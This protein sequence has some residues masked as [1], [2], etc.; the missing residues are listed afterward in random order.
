MTDFDLATQAHNLRVDRV[1]LDAGGCLS[2]AG[3]PYALIKGPTTSLWL[4]APPRA[5]AD[6]DLLVPASRLR[7]A[8]DALHAGGIASG[9]MSGALDEIG[10]SVELRNAAG[11]E[12][13]LHRSLPSLP[14]N[15]DSLWEA[16]A[17]HLVEFDLGVGSLPALDEV[18][19]CLTIAFHAVSGGGDL[20]RRWDDLKL[21]YAK[22]DARVWAEARAIAVRLGA[23]DLFDAAL[24]RVEVPPAAPLSRR[25]KLVLGDAEADVIALDRLAR[26]PWRHLPAFVFHELWPTDEFIRAADPVL[27]DRRA[28][29]LRA[30]LRRWWRLTRRFP[31]AFRTF[32]SAR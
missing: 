28:G 12:I 24:S 1:A 21:A 16:L 10:H 11:F 22:V 29:L 30:R 9:E 26:T 5:Y 17:G 32:R 13:D 2:R 31:A 25:A 23:E 19:R 20:S 8:V 27:A 6:V 4:Y 18:G 7:E 15:G 3:I 14:A